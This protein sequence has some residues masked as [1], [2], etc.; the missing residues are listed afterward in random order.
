V[1]KK[2]KQK[3]TKK[4]RRI[5]AKRRRRRL[6]RR[7]MQRLDPFWLSN[8]N[9]RTAAVRASLEKLQVTFPPMG[10]AAR[11]LMDRIRQRLAINKSTPSDE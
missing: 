7:M 4:Q 1:R 9:R 8:L 11:K 3:P 10:E 6:N 5:K 2:Q